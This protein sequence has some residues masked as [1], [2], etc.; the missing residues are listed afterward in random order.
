[1]LVEK[2]DEGLQPAGFL[3]EISRRTNQLLKFRQGCIANAF[4]IQR[5]SGTQFAQGPLN[6]C[7]RGI[8]REISPDDHFEPAA[9]GPPML[10]SPFPV[11]RPVISAN[12]FFKAPRACCGRGR[13]GITSHIHRG[14]CRAAPS[15]LKSMYTGVTDK[16]WR[17]KPAFHAEL[18]RCQRS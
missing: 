11:Q 12:L 3:P 9:C 16:R 10:A 18:P 6:V 2:G 8:L 13:D 17:R 5:A 7:P 14:R 15:L 4:E 1:V